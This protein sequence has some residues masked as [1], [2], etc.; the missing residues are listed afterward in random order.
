M[1]RGSAPTRIGLT[2]D[3]INGVFDTLSTH[4]PTNLFVNPSFCGDYDGV[5]S[6]VFQFG[7]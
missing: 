6:L 7:H 3:R 2:G 1:K 4:D 5:G